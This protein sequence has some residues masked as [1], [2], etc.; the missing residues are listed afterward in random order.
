MITLIIIIEDHNNHIRI[1]VIKRMDTYYLYV[2]HYK[3]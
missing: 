2:P 3:I 1:L